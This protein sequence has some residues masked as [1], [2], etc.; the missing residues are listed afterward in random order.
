MAAGALQLLRLSQLPGELALQQPQQVP[1]VGAFVMRLYYL[2]AA[3]KTVLTGLSLCI[4]NCRPI[5]CS[6]HVQCH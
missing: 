2:R 5:I 6:T 1:Q 4:A 3:P